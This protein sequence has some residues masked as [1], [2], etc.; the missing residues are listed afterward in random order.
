MEEINDMRTNFKG[1]TFSKY[2]KNESKKQLLNSFSLG[3]IES[4]CYWSAEFICAGHFKDLWD[5]ITIYFCK[6]I[7]IANP[8]LAIYIDMRFQ[9]FKHIVQ[10]GYDGSELNLRNN[11]KIRRLF[12]EIMCVLCLSRKKSGLEVIKIKKEDLNISNNLGKLRAKDTARAKEIFKNGDPSEIFIALN[13]LIYHISIKNHIQVWYWIE[14]ILEFDKL[15]SVKKKPLIAVRRE[16]APVSSSFQTNII[17]IVWSAF[18]SVTTNPLLKKILQSLLN[19][20]CIHFS[21][22]VKSKRKIVLYFAAYLLTEEYNVDIPIIS[23]NKTV[24]MVVNKIDII[25]SQIKKNEIS[26]ATDYL[27]NNSFTS[28]EKNLKNTINKIEKMNNIGIIRK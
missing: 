11:S 1:T 20:F 13:E 14:W 21:L 2:K 8:K 7:H 3:N 24:E 15:C 28:K 12:A 19:L 16:E 23:D 6:N 17:W 10:N 25:Y 27:F 4:A 18:F 9:H 5:I 26:P 22:G